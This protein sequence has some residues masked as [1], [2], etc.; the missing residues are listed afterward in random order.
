[1]KRFNR[2]SA[3]LS[4]CSYREGKDNERDSKMGTNAMIL[5]HLK[6]RLTT[7]A[8]SNNSSVLKLNSNEF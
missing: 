3:G 7:E 8:N 5:D 1:M 2:T 6:A 4:R